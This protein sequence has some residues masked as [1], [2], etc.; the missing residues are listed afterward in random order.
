VFV[1]RTQ[2]EGGVTD[3]VRQCGAIQRDALAGVNLR[4]P[5]QRQMIGIFRHQNLRNGG[6][7]RQS[8]L[9]QPGWGRRLHDTVLA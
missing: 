8:A 5:I 2:M 4:L 7:G 3:P 9:D 1:Q 6:F